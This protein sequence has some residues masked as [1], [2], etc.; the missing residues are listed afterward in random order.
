[1]KNNHLMIGGTGRAG[2]SYLVKLLHLCG[3][4]THLDH[5]FSEGQWH[6]KAQA[7]LEDR[8]IKNLRQPYV[9]KS[10]W[11][12]Q[13]IDS[14]LEDGDFVI[15]AVIIPVRN[16]MAAASSRVIIER[17]Y[18]ISTCREFYGPKQFDDVGYVPG[19]CVFSIN[20][21]DQA[22]ILAASFYELI[23]KLLERQVPTKMIAFPLF[24]N[25]WEYAYANLG[26]YLPTHISRD[27][28]EEAHSKLNSEGGVRVEVEL[29]AQGATLHSESTDHAPNSEKLSLIA[30]MR[31]V[32]SLKSEIQ[33]LRETQAGSNSEVQRLKSENDELKRM[34]HENFTKVGELKKKL[35]SIVG[36]ID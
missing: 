19:G 30:A 13:D 12:Y 9:M 23:H 6:E 11:L 32:L 10:P 33:N 24:A 15:D 34:N 17:Q 28:F 35:Q 25:D 18:Q 14:I 36:V 22:R 2:T 29:T 26:M 4:E 31:E 1:M 8:Y 21:I 20:A 3:L 16:L 27:S 5:D 7:G